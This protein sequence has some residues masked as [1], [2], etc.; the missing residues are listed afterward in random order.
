MH[1]CQPH[2]AKA[3]PSHQPL[4]HPSSNHLCE[5][6]LAHHSRNFCT[7]PSIF[8]YI[9]LP[10]LGISPYSQRS[11]FTLHHLLTQRS[12]ALSLTSRLQSLIWLSAL[13]TV[14]AIAPLA[15]IVAVLGFYHHEQ[16]VHYTF[17]FAWLHRKDCEMDSW[18]Q[19]CWVKVHTFRCC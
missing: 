19:N 6:L 1:P 4:S 7:K 10:L 2:S 18:K 15:D 14:L 3:L 16:R 17:I 8:E 9:S 13:H 12:N 5:Y 11:F